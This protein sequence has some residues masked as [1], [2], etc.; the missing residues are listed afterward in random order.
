VR[1]HDLFLYKLK[2]KRKIARAARPRNDENEE[3]ERE[4]C[5]N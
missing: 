3:C 4:I 1:R 5:E 2:K